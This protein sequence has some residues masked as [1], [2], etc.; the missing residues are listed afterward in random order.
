MKYLSGEE[1]RSKITD[2]ARKGISFLFAVD[3]LMTRG[4]VLTPAEAADNGIFYD[5]HGNTN[6][7][8]RSPAIQ[9]A[10][11][12]ADPV[13]LETYR[14]SFDRV[15]HHL[16]R[17]DTYLV[18]LTFPT[19][20]RSTVTPEQIFHRCS[21]PYKLFCRGR[22]LVFSP[23][24]FVQ[25]ID[26]TIASCPMKGTIDASIHGA[27][28][29]ILGDDKETFE[30]NTIVDL[31]RNDL[32]MVSTG[33]EVRR[34]RYIDRIHAN[35]GDLLQVSSEISGK[36]PRDWQY[37]LGE[38]LFTL[39]P[40]GSV[41]G[42]PKKK[43]VEIIRQAEIYERGFYTGICGYFDGACLDSGVMIRYIEQTPGGLV[44]KSGGGIT[45]LSRMKAEYDEMIQKVYVPVV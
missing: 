4:F 14:E 19:G 11:L 31:I 37:R 27:E 9:D 30:H 26:D 16:K 45:T 33:V 34:F 35:T 7:G 22:F 29:V 17:G 8:A 1:T 24:T 12:E 43:T 28:Q 2:Y 44:F 40:A 13:S 36:L 5:I 32:A 20:I 41:T 3:F 38:I 21:A 6:C 42:A 23:E 39:L 10:V 15:M 18:N 25:I